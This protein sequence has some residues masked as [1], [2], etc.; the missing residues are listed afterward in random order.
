MSPLEE[1]YRRL[2]RWLP[3]PARARWADDMTETYLSVTTADDPE[4]AEFGTPSAADRLDVARL[5]LALRLGAPGASVRAVAAGRTTRLVAAAGTV[6]LASMALA[7]LASTA[8][9]H[10]ALPFAT[11]PDLD[12][13]LTWGPLEAVGVVVSVL[14][15]ALAVCVVRGAAGARPLA[16]VVLAGGLLPVL[17]PRPELL[18]LLPLA[19]TAVPLV[20]AALLPAGVPLRRPWWLLAVPAVTAATWPLVFLPNPPAGFLLAL[21]DPAVQWAL[22]AAVTGVVL[23]ARRAARGPAELAVA[24]LAVATLPALAG[25]WRYDMTG[26]HAVVVAATVAV[27]VTAATVGAVGLRALRGLPADV[28]ADAGLPDRRWQAA[29]VHL[30]LVTLVVDDYD[31]AIRFFVDVLGFDLVEDSPAATNAGLPKRWVVVRPPGAETGLLLARAE[32]H[33]R[34]VI[35]DQV[36][37]RVGFFLRVDDVAATHARMVAAGVEFLS[38][39]RTEP[40]GRVA[41]FRDVAGNRWDLLGPA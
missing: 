29:G 11:A 24:V 13:P 18:D 6:A 7:G 39:P 35:G 23:L 27:V 4:Y 38:A 12:G 15:V 26:Y 2:L 19:T 31:P 10:G 1:R 25:R 30:P 14:T 17:A 9:A 34:R 32:E 33:Q 22:L 20:A 36:A 8:W 16:L 21:G 40:Y 28:P 37:D 5:A 3:E 41:V